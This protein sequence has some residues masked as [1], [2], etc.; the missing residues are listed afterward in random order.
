M[1]LLTPTTLPPHIAD[2]DVLEELLSR[3]SQALLDDLQ[4]LDGGILILGVGGKV[5]P[6]LARLAKRAAPT[7]RIVG[8]ARFSDPAVRDTS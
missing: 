8:V 5:G 6:T 1:N 2:V 4:R 7:K 3:P